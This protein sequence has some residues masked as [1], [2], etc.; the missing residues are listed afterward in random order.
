VTDGGEAGT[1]LTISIGP[2]D[3][4]F[5]VVD[6]G[7]GLPTE[8]H[9]RAF[10]PGYS[11]EEGG[12]GFGLAIVRSIA[13]AHGWSVAATEGPDGGARFEFRGVETLGDGP[14]EPTGNVGPAD[15]SADTR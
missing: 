7:V 3:D 15:R 1:P 2:L 14:G 10:E 13:D 8:C 6:D 5:Y 11:T 9:E 12:T 4:G